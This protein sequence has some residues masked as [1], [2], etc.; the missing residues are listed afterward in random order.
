VLKKFVRK[1]S[2][3]ILIREDQVKRGSLTLLELST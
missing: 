2:K 1:L 3:M